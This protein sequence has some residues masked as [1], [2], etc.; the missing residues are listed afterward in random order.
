M[1]WVQGL[2]GGQGLAGQTIHRVFQND[3]TPLYQAGTKG[4]TIGIIGGSNIDL[5]LV[6]DFQQLFGLLNNA[7]AC[8]RTAFAIFPTSRGLHRTAPT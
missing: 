3:I 7:R 4:T 6:S 2:A 8:L 1:A 5:A